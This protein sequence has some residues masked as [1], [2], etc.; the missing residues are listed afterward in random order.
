MLIYSPLIS[1]YD[2]ADAIEPNTI[3]IKTP[4][5][6]LKVGQTQQAVKLDIAINGYNFIGGFDFVFTEPLILHRSVPMAGPL[7]VSTNTFLIG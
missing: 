2:G 6:K 1:A 4:M 5:W 7:T 3:K